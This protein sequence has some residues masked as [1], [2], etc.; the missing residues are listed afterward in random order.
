MHGTHVNKPLCFSLINLSLDSLIYRVPAREP[1]TS[2]GKYFSPYKCVR[3]VHSNCE[4]GEMTKVRGLGKGL[5]KE[6]VIE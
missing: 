6:M 3:K 2:R 4:M 1:I 5:A